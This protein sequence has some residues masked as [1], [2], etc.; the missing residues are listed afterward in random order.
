MGT[1]ATMAHG[2]T[3]DL[4]LDFARPAR[5]SAPRALGAGLRLAFYRNPLYRISLNGRAPDALSVEP[6]DPWPG[7]AAN[8]DALFQGRFRFAGHEINAP[9]RPVWLP[10]DVSDAW[11]EDLH[12]FEWLRDFKAS[13]GDAARRHARALV[14]DWRRQFAAW[15]P[16]AWRADVLGR[17][18]AAWAVATG[19]LLNGA[20]SRFRKDFLD[21]LARQTRHLSRVVGREVVGAR[22]LA[23]IR[24]LLYG[25]ICL[26]QGP[27][28]LAQAERLLVREI[29]AQ[30]LGD[31][32]H[33]E[34]APWL[35]HQVLADLAD[36]RGLFLAANLAPPQQLVAALDRMAPMLRG[37]RH[38]DGG[39]A[40][41]NNSGEGEPWRIDAALTVSEAKGTAL[42]NAPHTGFQRLQAR[43]ALVLVDS[44]AP[45]ALAENTHAGT[46]SF[47]FSIAK[48]RL[49]V[50]CGPHRGR[51]AE[52][53]AA[54]RSTAAHSTLCV[55]DTNATEFAATG[56][57]RRPREVTCTR[58]EQDGTIWLELS[59]DGYLANFGL[60]H[61]RRLYLRGDGEDLR[62]EDNLEWTPPDAGRD[63]D[64]PPFAARFHLH[65]T[66][67]ASIVHN[68]KAVL[69]RMPGGAGWHFRASGGDL[70]LRPSVYFGDGGQHRRTEQIV[71]SGVTGA[72]GA[73]IKWGLRRVAAK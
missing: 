52:W 16:L 2:S 43:R 68:G 42:T 36:L 55:D 30:V 15:H 21:S 6:P 39:L 1:T 40:C 44:G 73:T 41:F 60:V 31:G 49:I 46:L 50:N 24:G 4:L 32:G 71:V 33:V 17:R 54:L 57:G 29:A 35:V 56:L 70:A 63:R 18:V 11:I 61:R 62:G 72:D 65:P 45:A 28:R 64:M 27:R 3:D 22:R 25:V 34:R 7:D 13:G 8:G 20:E 66:V 14:E 58:M 5:A 23:A 67:R 19:F 69:L 37:L 59:H 9:G 47:E 26:D 10:V 53:A 12:G 48:E 51:G 38:G